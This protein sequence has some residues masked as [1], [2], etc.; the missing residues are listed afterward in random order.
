MARFS[1][2]GLNPYTKRTGDSRWDWACTP[3]PQFLDHPLISMTLR[4][5][6]LVQFSCST[7]V[8][9]LEAWYLWDS[10]SFCQKILLLSSFWTKIRF[11]KSRSW[12][13]QST[14]HSSF[15]RN[16]SGPER[17]FSVMIVI[18][19]K[20]SIWGYGKYSWSVIMGL[21][22]FATHTTVCRGSLWYQ[23]PR[24][25]Y[26]QLPGLKNPSAK[27]SFLDSKRLLPVMDWF[28]VMIEMERLIQEGKRRI[29]SRE[30]RRT[31]I[32]SMVETSLSF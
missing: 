27:F 3:S 23:M 13:T 5:T 32:L 20:V 16:I 19:R 1:N 29:R 12:A 4:T 30:L 11:P 10:R 6:V 8:S 14:V 18:E 25:P 21:F 2:M 9:D 24:Y 28:K 22:L 17:K 26:L 7:Q 31:S 15:Q